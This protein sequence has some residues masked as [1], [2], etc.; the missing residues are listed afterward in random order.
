MGKVIY[1]GHQ[2]GSPSFYTQ[3]SD[4]NIKGYSK[5]VE[6]GDVFVFDKNFVSGYRVI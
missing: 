5:S 3:R 1:I 4:N 6:N 2:T